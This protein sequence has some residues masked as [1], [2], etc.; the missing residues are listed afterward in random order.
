MAQD[1]APTPC[2]LVVGAGDRPGTGAAIAERAAREGLHVFIAGRT[3]S[4]LDAL[5]SHIESVGGT[6]TG[7]VADCTDATAVEALF[8]QIS[9]SGASLRL[10]VHNMAAPNIPHG[11]LKTDADFFSNHWQTSVYA[12]YLMAQG[13]IRQMREQD[14]DAPYG[15]G[16]LIFTGASASLRGKARFS[17]FASAKAGLRNMA[18]AVAREFGPEDIHVAHVIIDGVIDGQFVRNAGGNLAKLWLKSKGNDGAL[19]P[20]AIADAF[21]MLHRQPRNAWTHEL[22]LRPFKEDW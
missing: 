13:A 19:D 11:F 3:Q 1:T 10:A 18:Q 12:G 7:I 4:K 2:A 15:R 14:I 6:A 16:T 17:A 20:E 8:E 5:V 9:A 21:W 22:D